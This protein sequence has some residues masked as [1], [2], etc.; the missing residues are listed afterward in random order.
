MELNGIIVIKKKK[1]LRDIKYTPFFIVKIIKCIQD[2]ITSGFT[3]YK[4]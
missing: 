2:Y 4:Y 1:T 3:N